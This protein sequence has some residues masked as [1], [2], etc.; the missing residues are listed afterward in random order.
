MSTLRRWWPMLVAALLMTVPA[1]ATVP[2]ISGFTTR[3]DG[4]TITAA[5]WNSELGGVYTYINNT[6]VTELNKFTV[7][8][9]ILSYDGASLIQLSNAGAGDD[10][11]VLTLDSTTASG[12]KWSAPGGTGLTTNGDTLYYN[13]GNQRLPIGTAGQVLTVSGGLPSWADNA[14]NI[15]TGVIVM[16]SGSIASIPAGWALCDGQSGR[17]NLQGLFIAG[18]GNVSPAASGGLG[19]LNPGVTGGSNTHSHTVS[20]TGTT[21]GPSATSIGDSTAVT[22]FASAGHTHTVSV[23]GTAASGSNAPKYYALAF[24][25]KV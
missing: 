16:W 10:A 12:L 2:N 23:S 8:G 7:K 24:I 19:L 4:N 11:K 14:S 18:A 17:P 9:G 20:A 3:A 22:T 6:L 15:P 1:L 5:I 21:A 13:S 25:I